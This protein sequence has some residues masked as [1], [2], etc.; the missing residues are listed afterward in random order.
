MVVSSHSL[1]K[2]RKNSS[3]NKTYHDLCVDYDSECGDCLESQRKRRLCFHIAHY[4]VLD[5]G[6]TSD[7]SYFSLEDV[8]LNLSTMSDTTNIGVASNNNSSTKAI[9]CS[10]CQPKF[11]KNNSYKKWARKSRC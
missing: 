5:D 3:S 6:D 9:K 7:S 4:P 2:K 8:D 10:I 1:D 11:Y